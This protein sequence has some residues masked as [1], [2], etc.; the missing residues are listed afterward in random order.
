MTQILTQSG[1]KT[2][3][4]L[5]VMKTL[6]ATSVQNNSIP[7]MR[8]IES[9]DPEETEAKRVRTCFVINFTLFV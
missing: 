3:Y 1:I 4:I 7:G 9:K 2:T 8:I 6:D 5:I